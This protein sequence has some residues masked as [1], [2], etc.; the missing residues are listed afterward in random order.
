MTK[1]IILWNAMSLS[2][3][4]RYALR[5]ELSRTLIGTQKLS[6]VP[7]VLRFSIDNTFKAQE[8]KL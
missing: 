1:Y 6:A 7:R 8:S 5:S 4:K 2:I 3:E